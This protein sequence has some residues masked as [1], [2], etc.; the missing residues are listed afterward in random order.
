M[1]ETL[2]LADL[3]HPYQEETD[4]KFAELLK[5]AFSINNG[6]LNIS[7]D[8]IDQF[9]KINFVLNGGE[10]IKT[11]H[12]HQ[13][14]LKNY[15]E[16]FGDLIRNAFEFSDVM[17][18]STT[19]GLMIPNELAVFEK[20]II[21]CL[22]GSKRTSICRGLDL[23]IAYNFFDYLQM[24]GWKQAV[25]KELDELYSFK[26][27]RLKSE[28][29]DQHTEY[30]L[31]V[32]F[33]EHPTFV[34]DTYYINYHYERFV[35]GINKFLLEK[36]RKRCLQLL[37]GFDIFSFISLLS[38]EKIGI[39][40]EYQVYRAISWFIESHPEI[41]QVE[42]DNLW[43]SLRVCSLSNQEFEELMSNS[44]ISENLKNEMQ[45]N[46]LKNYSE[47]EPRTYIQ[48][49]VYC[50][51][52]SGYIEV[53]DLY[54]E[55]CVTSLKVH[56]NI[57]HDIKTFKRENQNYIFTCGEDGHVILSRC[58]NDHS[59][60]EQLTSFKLE[61]PVL[62]MDLN[63]NFLV[64]NSSV[65]SIHIFDI[66]ISSP[67][68]PTPIFKE[69]QFERKADTSNVRC[70][71]LFG[72]YLIAGLVNGAVKMWYAGNL[73]EEWDVK[74]SHTDAVLYLKRV[75][76]DHKDYLLSASCDRSVVLWDISDAHFVQVKKIEVSNGF[77]YA[78]D[79]M[80]LSSDLSMNY[81]VTGST[82]RQVTI[83]KFDGQQSKALRSHKNFVYEVIVNNLS[84]ISFSDDNT[85]RVWNSESGECDQT[86]HPSSSIRCATLP[87]SCNS[88]LPHSTCPIQ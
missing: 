6:D 29:L 7:D 74:R 5:Q 84:I 41:N 81:I 68:D 34:I 87:S 58:S 33:T 44:T 64:V 66:S 32:F 1:T 75:T 43:K 20:I 35:I 30:F 42:R 57:I 80:L 55:K 67:T 45:N 14:A 3:T 46:R 79:V 19:I 27:I 59:I 23:V 61:S 77:V 8:A 15:S 36:N 76:I 54:R 62:T 60:L 26:S 78:V 9:W 88:V 28:C 69:V 37:L 82:D 85:I 51:S 12:L 48:S 50:G 31:R 56:S 13:E 17:E 47:L 52:I 4:P 38:N 63:D 70:V 16:L 21:P 86:F 40:S 10:Q 65:G 22:Y 2:P 25:K 53:W 24:E 18:K 72:D 39:Y 11:Y 83:A 73:S 49:I 71:C